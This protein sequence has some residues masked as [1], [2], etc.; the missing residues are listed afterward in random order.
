MLSER[1]GFRWVLIAAV[2]GTLAGAATVHAQ[3]PRPIDV[4]YGRDGAITAAAF[5]VA[6]A[7]TLLPVDAQ[8]RW[9]HELLPFDYRVRT[10][11]SASAAKTSDILLV[12]AIA[13]PAV[14][15]L[16]LGWNEETGKRSLVYAEALGAGLALN[17][18][19]KY[20]VGRPRPY[21][22]SEDPRIQAYSDHEGRDSRLSFFSGHAC[23][24]FAAAVAGGYLYSQ[25]TTDTTA[26]ALTWGIGL[27]LASATANLRV[28]AGKHFYSDILVGAVVGAGVGTLVPYLHYRDRDHNALSRGEW[29]A[30][31]AGPI[32]GILI[33]QLLPFK[34]DI[35]LPLADPKAESAP[36]VVLP[37][38]APRGQ[39][40][41]M[42]L[43]R[44][45]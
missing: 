34:R 33:S 15:E 30:I 35:T 29:V 23:T 12:L 40:G 3:G 32:A 21:T 20:T 8:A 22:Y 14:R 45:F 16:T 2:A 41:G 13:A 17:A 42:M 1:L 18:I 37:W 38:I 31:G 27:T 39:G 6:G 36:T 10:N 26:R 28:R 4:G 44:L 11:F 43:A 19:A 5:A 7:M 24:T 9:S 25:A